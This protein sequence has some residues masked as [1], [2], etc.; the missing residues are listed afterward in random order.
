M[1]RLSFAQRRAEL[2]EAAVRVI[3]R[4]GLAAA[5]TRAIVT[6]AG[7]P[8]GALHYVFE[9][10]EELLRALITEIAEAE[11]AAVL[12]ELDTSAVESVEDMMRAGLETYLRLLVRN[13]ER[14]LAVVELSL[15][16]ARH[17][18]RLAAEQWESYFAQA[19][20]SLERG[21]SLCGAVWIQP[22]DQIA[23]SLISVLDGLTLT[24]LATR[25]EAG[26]RRHIGFLA[27]SFAALAVPAKT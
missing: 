24:W 15:H 26:L 12:S 8:L 21:A 10:R 7:M 25:D 2:I 3:A 13:P 22:V 17:D 1:R 27:K 19:A 20:E 4:D 11:R 18:P 9:S 16:G 6:E 5:S 23:R 14:E